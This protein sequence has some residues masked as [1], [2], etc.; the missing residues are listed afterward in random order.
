MAKRKPEPKSEAVY[1]PEYGVAV[2]FLELLEFSQSTND[3]GENSDPLSTL[4]LSAVSVA[5]VDGKPMTADDIAFYF[6]IARTGDC[7]RL[8]PR[9]CPP[10]RR[11]RS[12]GALRGRGS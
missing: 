10:S 3:L 12:L 5:E 7:R 11:G 4:M 1:P 8:R 6:D 2:L 9:R